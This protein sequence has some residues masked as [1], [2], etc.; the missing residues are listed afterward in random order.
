MNP[1]IR[2]EHL[3]YEIIDIKTY[4]KENNEVYTVVEYWKD[5]IPMRRTFINYLKEEDN[6]TI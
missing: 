5:N 3:D 1:L 4:I 6:E 2:I